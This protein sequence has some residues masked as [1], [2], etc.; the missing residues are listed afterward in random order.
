MI[1]TNLFLFLCRTIDWMLI[2]MVYV[3]NFKEYT[4]EIWHITKEVH[5]NV[6]IHCD[7]MLSTHSNIIIH[8][9]IIMDVPSNVITH[10]CATME[11]P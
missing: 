1:T 7:A 6:I 10:C 3:Y 4:G 9:D 11:H 8:C 2:L 5:S